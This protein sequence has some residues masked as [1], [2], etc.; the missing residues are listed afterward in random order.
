MHFIRNISVICSITLSAIRPVPYIIIGYFTYL[1]LLIIKFKPAIFTPPRK[2]LKSNI[3]L[4][5]QYHV[6]DFYL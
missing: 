1:S 3:F 4:L 6:W 5:F 2:C